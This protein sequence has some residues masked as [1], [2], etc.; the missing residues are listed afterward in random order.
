MCQSLI[1]GMK[2]NLEGK[3]Q[4]LKAKHAYSDE[5]ERM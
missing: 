2:N 1:N 5:Y 4:K 3:K